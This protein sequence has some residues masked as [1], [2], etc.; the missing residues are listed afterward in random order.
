MVALP[1]CISLAPDGGALGS[2]CRTL[3]RTS[4]CCVTW[5]PAPSSSAAWRRLRLSKRAPVVAS[6][7]NAAGAR[8]HLRVCHRPSTSGAEGR[9]DP[10]AKG[11]HGRSYEA[12][13]DEE[14]QLR[15]CVPHR[16]TGRLDQAHRVR[17]RQP[18]PGRSEIGRGG[19]CRDQ[20]GRCGKRSVR[21]AAPLRHIWFQPRRERL[22]SHLTAKTLT[23]M[24]VVFDC[25]GPKGKQITV[26][27]LRF[28][29]TRSG[30]S[31]PDGTA[32]RHELKV[33]CP[34]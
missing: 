19:Q 31:G 23:A 5:R 15:L 21:E 2:S 20:P 14:R 34:R 28:A 4:W 9:R 11:V 22:R 24:T 33:T 10:Y 29:T 13:Y 6:H 1:R 12:P 8:G 17:R 3:R 30:G 26:E 16:P 18:R 32:A 7:G 27:G 25:A